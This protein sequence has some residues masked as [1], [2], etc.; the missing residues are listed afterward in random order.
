MNEPAV[1]LF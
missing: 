1:L